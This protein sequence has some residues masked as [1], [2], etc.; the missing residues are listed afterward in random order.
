MK[1]STEPIRNTF[2]KNV[3]E[4]R[5]VLKYSQEILA[6]K[7]KLSVQTIKDI[8]GCR[9]WISDSSLTKLAKALNISEY[10]LLLPE[11]QNV[12]KKHK[13]SVEKS[14]LFLKERLKGIIDDQIEITINT[15]DFS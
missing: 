9:R 5:S 10:Q 8:E 12:D 2:A 11:K 3:K 14:L 4:Y 15:S 6:E 1:L 13:K 7:A